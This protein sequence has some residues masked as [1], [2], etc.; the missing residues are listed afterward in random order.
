MESI[1]ATHLSHREFA[2]STFNGTWNLLDRAELS[3]EEQIELER[4]ASASLY[5]WSI[6]GGPQELATG[7]WLLARVYIR[8]GFGHE[9]LRH[10]SMAAEL[11]SQNEV[12]DYL[13][14]STLE[15]LARAHAMM[16][17]VDD[18]IALRATAVAALGEIADPED[19]ELIESQI[20][21]GP[22]FG[23]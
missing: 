15:G 20:E 6:I 1:H 14:A 9:A 21:E 3:A 18:A 11:A 12:A 23:I 5:H 10:A 2:V 13:K 22:W 19:R 8:L 7:E 4:M 17:I 16:G